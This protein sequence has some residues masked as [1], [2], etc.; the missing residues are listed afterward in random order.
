MKP[1]WGVIVSQKTKKILGCKDV[2]ELPLGQKSFWYLPLRVCLLYK[3]KEVYSTTG[4][5]SRLQ[6]RDVSE[7]LQST[8]I[9]FLSGIK[10]ES[11]E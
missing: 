8:V 2:Q 5:S 1:T 4:K 7:N 6:Q 10:E 3:S 9:D 11:E